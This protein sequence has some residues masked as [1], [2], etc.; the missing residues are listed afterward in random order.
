[1]MKNNDFFICDEDNVF[2]QLSALYEDL[3]PSLYSNAPT[4]DPNLEWD[5]LDVD[6]GRSFSEDYDAYDV[7]F[8]TGDILLASVY[9]ENHDKMNLRHLHR[10]FLVIYANARMTYGFQL[11]TSSPATLTKYLVEIPN[12]ADCGLNGP[13]KFVLNMVR[14]VD[15]GR[16]LKRIGHITAEQRQA[17][18]DKLYEIRDNKDGIYDD[19]PLNDRLD[20]TISNV[21]RIYC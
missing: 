13:G 3:Q 12:Y 2:D 5:G 14:G 15:H 17:I 11:S 8:Q 16:L 9:Q 19:C 6:E 10:P 1:M 20:A 7:D 18:L 21:A 4:L